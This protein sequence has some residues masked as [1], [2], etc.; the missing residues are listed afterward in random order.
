VT[1][2]ASGSFDDRIFFSY[3]PPGNS[4]PGAADPSVSGYVPSDGFGFYIGS[5]ADGIVSGNSHRFQVMARGDD[6][7]FVVQRN[8]NNLDHMTLM[9]SLV[10]PLHIA[11]KNSRSEECQ[12]TRWDAG[13]WVG[14]WF[15][16]DNTTR[17]GQD[18]E[19]TIDN[20]SWLTTSVN[21]AAPWVK[22]P[23]LL[24]FPIY[25]NL[26]DEVSNLSGLKGK[27]NEEVFRWTVSGGP[28][29]KQRLA[30]GNLIHIDDGVVLG[31]D[32]SNGAMS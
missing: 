10:D 28:S 13:N 32:S 2:W 20:Y 23:L 29:S 26:G 21:N 14:S 19:C 25:P 18:S 3:W 16:A 24:G 27:V 1:D 17:I 4:G 11:D 7:L 5:R 31:Y 15:A 12:I 22:L 30:G 9:G 8:S 6:L